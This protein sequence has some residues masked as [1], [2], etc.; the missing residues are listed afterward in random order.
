[1]KK[2]KK[3]ICF[4]ASLSFLMTLTCML[5]GMKTTYL[6]IFQEV[7]VRLNMLMDQIR[8]FM[9]AVMKKG[10]KNKKKMKSKMMMKRQP[11]PKW[12]TGYGKPM[13][14][15]KFNVKI[16]RNG[17]HAGCGRKKLECG[18]NGMKKVS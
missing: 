3:N 12:S 11:T 16:L 14:K 1:M 10:L 18:V 17:R 13:E 9:N 15:N 7:N 5:I 6:S 4:P 2:V 8:I